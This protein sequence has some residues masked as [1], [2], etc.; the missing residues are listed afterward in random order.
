M[1]SP[2]TEEQIKFLLANYENK[3]TQFLM[4]FL[5]N[6]TNDQIRWKAKEY[7]LHKKVTKSKS[8][9]SFLENFDDKESLY[10][11]GFLT[12]DGCI[13]KRQI[14]F[15]LEEKDK[16]YVIKFANKC[17]TIVSYPKRINSWHKTYYTMARACVSDK[18]TIER[19][20]NKLKIQPQKTYNPFDIS[21]FLT[22]DRLIYYFAG[23]VDGDGH[24]SQEG[25]AITIK[26]H[27]N[28]K[29]NFDLIAQKFKDFY[30]INLLVNINNEGWVTLRSNS[31]DTI[32][33]WQ[34][35]GGA[36]DIMPRKW[37]RIENRYNRLQISPT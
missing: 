14:I 17:K 36:L 12:A 19:L 11:W 13:T 7:K 5:K 2:W 23:L 33:I 6:K 21:I 20:I 29:H 28:W 26:V 34:L 25:T 31:T 22:K 18:Y 24:I 10:W 15:S 1:K 4:D 37:S 3:K 30:D 32:K 35:L 16:E 8:D 27:S 9:I